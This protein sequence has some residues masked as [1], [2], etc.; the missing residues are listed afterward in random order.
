MI[1][2]IRMIKADFMKLK[3]TPFYWIH[4]CV[5]F[6]GIVLFLS[7]Y[8]ISSMKAIGKVSG[9][10]QA[11]ALVFPILIGVVCAL[12]VE[13]EAMA[14]SFKEML[15]SAY[16]KQKSLLSK[17][18]VLLISGLISTTM[19][20][21][22]FFLGFKY[23]LHQNVLPLALYG[24]IILIIFGSQIFLYLFHVWLSFL[25]GNGASVGI[26]IFESLVSAL[27]ITGLGDG[28]WQ[29]IPCAWG[30]RFCEYFIIKWNNIGW[31]HKLQSEVRS[32]NMSSIIL[33][34]LFAL[35]LVIWFN[36]YEGR[37]EK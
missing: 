21:G 22:G 15:G 10:A 36:F 24:N 9:Y 7:Y 27:M 13:Q 23:I 25:W 3:N 2:F 18:S 32:G 26:G 30:I 11:I 4:L 12:V 28:I 1:T 20:V 37:K 14:G 35:F 31:T 16:G 17:L 29:F 5:P 6:T 19:A 33:T 34:I 8:S